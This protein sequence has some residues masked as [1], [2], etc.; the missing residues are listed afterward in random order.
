MI[1]IDLTDTDSQLNILN[2]FSIDMVDLTDKSQLYWH[3][4]RE[5]VSKLG[6]VDCVL[7]ELDIEN[8][9]LIQ[10]AAYG[11]KNP[12]E[13]EIVN[14]LTIPLG[15]GVTGTVALTGKPLIVE[16]TRSDERFIVDIQ[17][18]LSEICVPLIYAGKVRGVIDCENPHKAHFNQS[19]L[20]ALT[21]VAAMLSAK[22]LQYDIN[23]ELQQTNLALNREVAKSK[24]AEQALR[25]HRYQLESIVEQR[26]QALQK[27]L[28]DL[29]KEIENKLR[30]EEDLV[31][32]QAILSQSAKMASIGLLAAGVAH[33]INNPMAFVQSNLQTLEEYIKDISY[34]L[35]IQSELTKKVLSDSA[36]AKLLA[37]NIKSYQDSIGLSEIQANFTEL[38]KIVL[39]GAQR[40]TRIV[41]ELKEFAHEDIDTWQKSDIN[42]L[43]D[44]ALSI[45]N[46]EL[47]SKAKVVTDY[48]KDANAFCF[49]D[50][51][52]QVFLNLLV[53]AAQSMKVY[54]EVIITTR[55]RTTEI[56]I[57]ISDNGCGIPPE[58][59]EKIF[60]PFFTT[61][62]VG[63]GTGLGLHMAYN[64][65]ENHGGT[66]LAKSQIGKGTTMTI[67]L[68][69]NHLEDA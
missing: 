28:T 63:K 55:H 22:L 52:E 60:E 64:I 20:R 68:P 21:T 27:S 61:K 18:N 8:D 23:Q 16:D 32:N 38:I 9:V 69:I 47:K 4:A 6:F 45:A 3:V 24:A 10:K 42:S 53:N 17:D 2:Q 5:V 25:E 62:E 44:K 13:E 54:G 33:E 40:V 58:H 51:L 46:N 43:I 15:K 48:A 31:R 56:E 37:E 29:E 66:I 19:H 7:Y 34:L 12:E 57:E 1:D 59:L 50:K 14:L 36:E 49:S 67:R 30:A 11:D 65:I 26:T 41:T 39:N 35:D